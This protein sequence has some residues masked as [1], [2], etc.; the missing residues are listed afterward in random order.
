MP[1]NSS[2]ARDKTT[3]PASAWTQY[4]SWS[5]HT[6]KGTVLGSLGL[7]GMH[8]S[9]L[10][11]RIPESS[12]PL[13][14]VRMCR[15]VWS[16]ARACAHFPLHPQTPPNL[17]YE[18]R[19][20]LS[21]DHVHT[22][23]LPRHTRHRGT[24]LPLPTASQSGSDIGSYGAPLTDRWPS[25]PS[26]FYSPLAP[27]RP[28]YFANTRN[29]RSWSATDISLV[30]PPDAERA[31]TPSTRAV[32][33]SSY[34]RARAHSS[35]SKYAS[36]ESDTP[37][38]IITIGQMSTA[39]YLR[40]VG[41]PSLDGMPLQRPSRAPPSAFHFPFQAYGGNPD[42]GLSIPGLGYRSGR[43]STESLHAAYASATPGPARRPLQA[44]SFHGPHTMFR[45]SPEG[46]SWVDHDL[47]PPY[48]PFMSQSGSQP[49]RNSDPT[50]QNSSNGSST[51]PFRAPFLSPASRPSSIWSPPSHAT[52]SHTALPTVP[53]QAGSE[54][55]PKPPL[56][57][58]L[59]A[60]KLTKEDKPWLSERPDGRTRSSRW[61]TLFMLFLGA[62]GAGLLCWTGYSDAGKTMIDPRH[63]CL[64]MEDTFDN[65][66]VDNGGTWTRDV[67]MSGFGYVSC[68]FTES[69]RTKFFSCPGMASLKWLLRFRT[70]CLCAMVSFT[71]SRLSPRMRCQTL[72][73]SSMEAT[74]RFRV[75]QHSRRTLRLARRHRVISMGRP[76]PQ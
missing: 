65:L 37:P 30:P 67:E 39:P 36:V 24:S 22:M 23:S 61:V 21:K 7:F 55:T 2:I 9:E 12:Q 31:P 40:D 50:T 28:F 34:V 76:S 75:A 49:N 15:L 69:V 20:P 10:G 32:T 72:S 64:V 16:S 53:P 58:T 4:E 73:K 63:L 1:K 44:P 5:K 51:P 59:L 14:S 19:I 56:P 42:P 62:C 54:I 46:G 74:I 70:T 68:H 38:S 11:A 6:S 27:P 57:S 71:S 8:Q 3:R 35:A 47:E 52:Y 13:S 43:S 41:T 26:R 60:Q 48:P 17:I 45:A 66:D 18:R 29:R 25:S 33:P